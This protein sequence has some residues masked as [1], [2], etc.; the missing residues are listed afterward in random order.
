MITSRDR[1]FPVQNESSGLKSE[2]QGS[3]RV[4]SVSNRRLAF[5]EAGRDRDCGAGCRAAAIPGTSD[6]SMVAKTVSLKQHPST[7]TIFFAETSV[8]V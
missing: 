2:S 8:N 4:F 7:L 3:K 1:L 5:F 6:E